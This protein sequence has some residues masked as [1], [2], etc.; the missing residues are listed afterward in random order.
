MLSTDVSLHAIAAKKWGRNEK[1]GREI[2]GEEAEATT[3]GRRRRRRLK[4]PPSLRNN[5]YAKLL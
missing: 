5:F 3:V 1:R 4:A 2:G